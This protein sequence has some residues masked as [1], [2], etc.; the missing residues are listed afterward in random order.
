MLF[1]ETLLWQWASNRR[2]LRSFRHPT[3]RNSLLGRLHSAP[4]LQELAS[5]YSTVELL[6]T[7][8]GIFLEGLHPHWA[9]NDILFVTFRKLS[10][11][12]HCHSLYGTDLCLHLSVRP[13]AF[14]SHCLFYLYCYLSTLTIRSMF[15]TISRQI[16]LPFYLASSYLQSFEMVVSRS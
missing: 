8:L 13:P 7:Q 1:W 4:S 3:L 5:K 16:P 15:T 2:C 9:R 12:V 14:L 11:T 10:F 6:L